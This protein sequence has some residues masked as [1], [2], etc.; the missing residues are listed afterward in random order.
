LSANPATAGKASLSFDAGLVNLAQAPFS[1]DIA[2]QYLAI[3]CA[4]HAKRTR[5]EAARREGNP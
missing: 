3:Y 4:F 2:P 5:V 1:C